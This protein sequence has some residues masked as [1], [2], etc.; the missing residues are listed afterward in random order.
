MARQLIR[1]GADIVTIERPVVT[2]NYAK[3]LDFSTDK[4]QT[5]SLETLEHSNM[6]RNAQG[7]PLNGIFHA[8]LVHKVLDLVKKHGYQPDIYDMFAANGGPSSLPG[9]TLSKEL[10]LRYGLQS[11][12]AHTLRRVYANITLNAFDDENFTTNLA[13]SFHQNGI[14]IGFGPMVKICHNQTMLGGGDRVKTFGGNGTS[15]EGALATVDG[16]MKNAKQII[17]KRMM[18]VELLKRRAVDVH[19]VYETIGQLSC[20]R[21]LHDTK[22]PEIKSNTPYEMNGV[23]INKYIEQIAVHQKDHEQLTVWDLYDAGTEVFQPSVTDQP[24]VL[25]FNENLN[26]FL[27]TKF[28]LTDARNKIMAADLSK[29][30]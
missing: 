25:D 2:T 1:K 7:N 30:Y 19:E 14:E 23:L 16:W 28:N 4:V 3:T 15:V 24:N 9:V 5:I 17:C 10:E 13:V 29:L 11:T 12:E 20:N 6:E 26:E 8:E 22:N 21:V 27:F 18:L